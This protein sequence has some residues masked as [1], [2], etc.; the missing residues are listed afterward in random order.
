MKNVQKIKMK[1]SFFD[2]IYYSTFVKR[3]DDHFMFGD[4][5]IEIDDSIKENYEVVYLQS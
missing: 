2:Q 5:F 1:Q 3:E 4:I